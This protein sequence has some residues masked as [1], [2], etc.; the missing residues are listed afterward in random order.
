MENQC[1]QE[2]RSRLA[3]G[4]LRYET[5]S[6]TRFR[7]NSHNHLDRSCSSNRICFG[8][9]RPRW[10]FE[11]PCTK[12]SLINLLCIGC[13]SSKHTLADRKCNPLLEQI[14][15]KLMNRNVPAYQAQAMA[16][17]NSSTIVSN[18]IHSQARHSFPGT[19]IQST[20]R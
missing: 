10:S 18:I 11:Y 8:A 13:G 15:T 12:Q 4:F 19:L 6:P 7:N 17:F 20:E 1:Y 14:K 9:K 5:R 2:V 3:R 16:Q